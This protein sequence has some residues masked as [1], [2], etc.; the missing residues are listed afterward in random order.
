MPNGHERTFM[1]GTAVC[2][3]DTGVLVLTL[4]LCDISLAEIAAREVCVR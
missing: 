3:I 2:T 4:A 1:G